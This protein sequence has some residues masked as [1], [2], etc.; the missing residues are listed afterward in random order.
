MRESYKSAFD[1]MGKGKYADGYMELLDTNLQFGATT[2]PFIAQFADQ[3]NQTAKQMESALYREAQYG[4][5][6][7]GGGGT[8]PAMG[9]SGAATA[10]G[11]MYGNQPM[12]TT[13]TVTT[14]TVTTGNPPGQPT[15]T[16]LPPGVEPDLPEGDG[17]AEASALTADQAAQPDPAMA[18]V[19]GMGEPDA[20]QKAAAASAAQAFS[21]PS[22]TQ[23]KVIENTI[24]GKA[25][26]GISWKPQQVEGLSRLFP[27]QNISDIIN[28][29]PVG[30]KVNFS[31]TWTGKT[32]Q[33]G[34]QFTGRKDIV[35]DDKMNLRANEFAIELQKSVNILTQT[36]PEGEDKY[37]ADIIEEAG[38]IENVIPQRPKTQSDTPKIKPKGKDAIEVAPE[39]FM[40]IAE[41][42]GLSAIA[43]ETGIKLTPAGGP[44]TGELRSRRFGSVEEALMSGATNGQQVY[45]LEAGKYMPRQFTSQDRQALEWANANPNDPQAAQI[46]TRLRIK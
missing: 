36:G 39:V 25:D 1:K 23:T 41:I 8:L 46:K 10:M 20:V 14:D 45:V 7:V 2:N 17:G 33:P 28:I 43:A 12:D 24:V 21:A 19:P 31:E 29:A 42:K 40:A 32:N 38:G 35:V 5:R 26:E 30:S 3:A 9:P 15:A 4:G 37:W 6:G 11:R 27:K 34:A 44:A 22:A 16:L 18:G 13:E